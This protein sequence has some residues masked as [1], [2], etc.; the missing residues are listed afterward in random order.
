LSKKIIAGREVDQE[1]SAAIRA[2]VHVWARTAESQRKPSS[3]SQLAIELGV[4]RPYV[5]KLVKRLATVPIPVIVQP[6]NSVTDL[7]TPAVTS[8]TVCPATG[9]PQQFIESGDLQAIT[10]HTDITRK[11]AELAKSGDTKA[12]R[13]YFE[14]IAGPYRADGQTKREAVPPVV[15]VAIG[16]LPQIARQVVNNSQLDDSSQVTD[17][18]ELVS[19]KLLATKES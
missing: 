11:I 13:L 15:Q 5:S 3:I 7:V 9:T 18:N 14:H 2:R 1:R 6:D 8:P 10:A 17:S 4:S 19:L 16:W 12:A